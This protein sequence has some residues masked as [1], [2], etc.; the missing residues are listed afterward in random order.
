LERLGEVAR[1]M[2]APS[3]E[4]NIDELSRMAITLL[5][6]LQKSVSLDITLSDLGVEPSMLPT[7]AEDAMRTMGG[8]VTVTPGNLQTIDL[9]KIYRMSI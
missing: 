4:I 9:L 8:L 7:L 2:G 1:V 3:R 6:R 5:R